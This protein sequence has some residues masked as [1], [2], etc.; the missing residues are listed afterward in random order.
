MRTR[1][2]EGSWVSRGKRHSAARD[3]TAPSGAWRV[4]GP[5]SGARVAQSVEQRTGA[6][7]VS[8]IS[9]LRHQLWLFVREG[10]LHRQTSGARRHGTPEQRFTTPR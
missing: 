3:Q 1:T 5:S 10:G 8:L 7:V 2:T 6:R 4:S 9:D